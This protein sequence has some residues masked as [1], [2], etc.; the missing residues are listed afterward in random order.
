MVLRFNY[1]VLLFHGAPTL[2]LPDLYVSVSLFIFHS[3]TNTLDIR[4]CVLGV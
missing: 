1:G 3:P 4:N 2:I